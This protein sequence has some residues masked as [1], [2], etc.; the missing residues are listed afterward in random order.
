MR[1]L[2]LL[3]IRLYQKTL[4]PDHGPF[5]VLYS[6]RMCRFHPTCSQYTYE[7]I[8]RFGFWKGWWLGVRRIGRCHP[9]NDGGYD[10]VPERKIKSSG[11]STK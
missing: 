1:K 6:E 11:K 3:M 10:P 8:E 5:S 7:A 9:W 2:S 4:S